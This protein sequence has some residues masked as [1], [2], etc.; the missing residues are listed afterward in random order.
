MCC[1]TIANCHFHKSNHQ[2]DE[3]RLF[4]LT[5]STERNI[6]SHLKECNEF[7]MNMSEKQMTRYY[8]IVNQSEVI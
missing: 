7:N 3:F 6:N 1:F 5:K 2:L 4:K 8:D